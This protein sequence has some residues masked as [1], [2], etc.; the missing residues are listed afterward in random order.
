MI[1]VHQLVYTITDFH[2]NVTVHYRVDESP[3]LER[4]LCQ[5]NLVHS[6]TSWCPEI[7]FNIITMKFTLK[8]YKWYIFFRIS[9][10]IFV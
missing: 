3:P 2:L 5:I 1:I 6:H 9:D 7:R 4:T 10:Y 8:S